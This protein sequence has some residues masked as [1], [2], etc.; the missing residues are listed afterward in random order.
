MKKVFKVIGIVLLVI[1][2]L[3]VLLFV[4]AAL[5]Q[6]AP[7]DYTETV[8]TGGEIETTYL[9]NGNYKVTYFEQKVDEDFE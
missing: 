9:R 2:G 3:I 1:V 7:A 5:T 8:K 6:M 4:K